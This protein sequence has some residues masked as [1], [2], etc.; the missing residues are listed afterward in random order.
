MFCNITQIA[1]VKGASVTFHSIF[2]TC[3][4]TAKRLYPPHILNAGAILVCCCAILMT[5]CGTTTNRVAT[6]Q[7]LVSNAIDEAVAQIDFSGLAGS[8]V[9]LDDTYLKD[10]K[11]AGI[12]NTNYVTS[13]LRQQ[14]TAAGCQIF[15]SEKDV[16]IIV[17]PRI[18]AMGTDGHKVTYG[19][20]KTGGL[21]AAATALSGSPVG[22]IPEISFAQTD[23]QSA[24]AKVVVFAY[25]RET[26]QPVWQS[27]I[28][29]AESNSSS[30]WV[31]GAGPF[32]KGTMYD[33][34]RFAGRDINHVGRGNIIRSGLIRRANVATKNTNPLRYDSAYVFPSAAPAPLAQQAKDSNTDA[35]TTT[36]AKPEAV[37]EK[38]KNIHKDD[39][40]KR[41]SFEEE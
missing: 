31:L 36:D 30:T 40:V 3:S 2:I 27:G 24:V 7:L 33:S 9:Y 18:G 15:D 38:D 22:A 39:S 35:K 1:N 11:K 8:K 13:S 4:V 23:A 14:L 41:A 12:V 5:G 37:A 25:Q 19:I 21:S 10:D 20:P 6:E 28:A 17:E 34:T 32:E 26:R 29:K 16:D